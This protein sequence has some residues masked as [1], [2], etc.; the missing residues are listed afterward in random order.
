MAINFLS[1]I[2]V[3]GS[4]SLT[5]ISND[6]STYTGVVVWDGGVLKYRTKAQ[7]LSDIG[8]T[9]NTGTVTSVTV[10]GTTGLSGS[11]T[12]T[13]SGTITLTN[14]D[15]G[16]SQAIYKNIASDS[17]TATANSNND[18]LTIAGGTNVST[19]RSGDT[20]TINATDT[21]TNNYVSSLSWNTGTGVLTAARSGLSSLTVDLDG[22]YVT[23]S[24][25]TS[26]ATG[27]GIGG[28]TITSTG[29]LTVG[30]GDGL[31]Q[32]STG[33]LMSGS[34][35][36][37]FAVGST[38]STSRT[39]RVLA[40][41]SYTAGLEAYGSSQGTGYAYVGQSS[42]Y[43]GGM[44]YNGDGSPAFAT[45][46]QSDAISFYRRAASV[47]EVVF[48]YSY[49]NN[50]VTFRGDMTV[51]G[52]DITLGGTGR[53]Q[54]IDTVTSSTDAANKAYVDAAVA[55][56][57]VGDITN[58]TA[59]TGMTG[60]GSS[61]SVTLNVIGGDGI[62]ANNDNI[63]VDSTV[64]RTSGTQSIAGA[65][66][67]TTT[68][69]SVTRSTADSS[70][71]LATTA[72]VKNQGY[73][74]NVGDITNV[75]TTSPITGGGSSGSV[76]IAHANSGVTAGSY[77]RA[78]VTVNATG[79][80]TSI[81]ANSDAQGVT[82]V[83]TSGTVSGLTLTGGTITSTGTITL[84]GTLSLTSANV[85]SGLGFT[86]YNA[87]NPAGY[88]TN[89]GT[90]T[91]SNT[92]TFTNKSGN[93]SQ[94]TNNSGY[95][96]SASLPTVNNAT[97][98]ITT[99]TGLDGATSF[100]LNQSVNKTIAL[101]L[102]LSEF[103][104][105]TAAMN[106]NDEFIVL[107]S[108]A[109][110]R[111]R[112]GEIGLSIFSNDSG[113]TSFAEPGIFSGGG[114]PTLASGVTGTEIRTL[115]GAGTSSSAGV[116]S[117]A[118]STGLSGGTITST[119]TLTNTDRGSSQNIFKN[120]T[121]SSGGTATANSNNDTLTIAAGTN[122]TT[123][124]S[125]DTITINATND[126]Q[127]VTSIA[128]GSGISG[129]TITSTGTLTVGAGNGLSQSSTGLLM[130]G[131]YTG[132]F[133]ASGDITIGGRDLIFSNTGTNDANITSS[134]G[135]NF[136]VAPSGISGLEIDSAGGVTT[137]NVLTT[138]GSIIVGGGGI[139]LNGT[140]RI[141]GIDTVSAGTDAANKTYVDNAVAGV[142]QG[143]ITGVT[144]GTN[145][146]GGGTSGAVTLNLDSAI[147]LT[148]IQLGSFVTLTESTDRAD[149]LYINSSTS[150][151]GGLQ[152][153]NTSNE[154]I[155]SLMGDGSVGGIYDDQNADWLIQWT[156]NSA[157]RLYFN[158]GQKLTTTNTGVTITGTASAT[159]FN[160]ALSG[161]ATTATTLQTARTIAGVSFNGSANISLNNNA[162]TNGAGY[163]TNTG[164]VT[165]SG[166]TGR[167]PYW[168]SS[169]ALSSSGGF[170]FN[171][172]STSL[173]VN[174]QY[175]IKPGISLAQYSAV[176]DTNTGLGGFDGNF[177]VSL[178]SKN[179]KIISISTGAIL[180]DQ[181]I[182]TAVST[183]LG[184][185]LNANQNFQAA[186]EDTLALL[187]VDTTG[188]VVR[189]SQE[190]TWTFTKAELD[191]LTTSTTSG[192]TII[193]APGSDKA[194]II[195]ES[196]WMIKYSGTGTMSSNSFAIR[197]AHNGDSSAEISR[198]PSGQINTIMSSAPA[199]PS[200]GFYSRDLPLYNNDGRSFVTNKTTFL[201]RISTNALPTNLISISIKL[202]YRL[203]DVDTF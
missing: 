51:S 109:E 72:F 67:F 63:T 6:N 180:F 13:T 74:T 169:S 147:E 8:G 43:G 81:S 113:F 41:D 134:L 10:Q 186:S 104:D 56:V 48:Y 183:G 165:G 29:T 55:G 91:A 12:I 163:T 133:T 53:I 190:G 47:N 60:G 37:S 21:T 141:T 128:T 166:A 107:D 125:G 106:T 32:S 31:A 34:Y 152:I 82:S 172:S 42:S 4:V 114:T 159:T 38:S 59:G 98:T 93:I 86:P 36:G 192:N 108:S 120:F 19:A 154:F 184:Y 148:Q 158:G 39:I 196:N 50:N 45:G 100:T 33:L 187:A 75:S 14:S 102:D 193:A 90:T 103:T 131:S 151:W 30:A 79:H 1:S 99:A 40:G 185:S 54:G 89:T 15:R 119:G 145:L 162:I 28:G 140:G 76:T 96:T 116:T 62:T 117:I 179:T 170:E 150:S 18:T 168:S 95:I 65:K 122:I 146:N 178:V 142:P 121:A 97:I 202:K 3:S 69:I 73:T 123:V 200:Y 101:S 71:Y 20:I 149:L 17:G 27:N 124:R 35:S 26:V 171:S 9:G 156:E 136:I 46:E 24:G 118:T 173:T 143:D 78:T 188:N 84:G 181:Y 57:P 164:T 135:I 199:N 7:I 160:G 2:S 85:T 197:Q 127:G 182:A 94:W 176:G 25:V 66:T 174:N 155:F 112:A 137:F 92:Q 58:V 68:P 201:N 139:Q 111:K 195:E 23:S 110:R 153:G 88:T 177:G 157:V 64:V 87:T 44:F 198:L 115:I 11:G 49:I 5:S 191:S 70:T 16:S 22:R 203:F 167:V 61:G 132:D 83:A 138:G 105:M 189:G 52:G 126:G 130:S 80:V 129:G 77:A 175:L 161:N 194:V 144:A